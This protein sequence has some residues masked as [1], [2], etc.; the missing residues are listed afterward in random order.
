MIELVYPWKWLGDSVGSAFVLRFPWIDAFMGAVRGAQ[1][2][3]VLVPEA[4]GPLASWGRWLDDR[5][6]DAGMR[7]LLADSGDFRDVTIVLSDAY[8][9]EHRPEGD[10]SAAWSRSFLAECRREMPRVTTVP[11]LVTGADDACASALSEMIRAQRDLGYAFARPVLL[12]RTAPPGWDGEVVRLGLPEWVGDLNRI[13]PPP[14]RDMEFWT[15]L[16][17]ALAVA[18]EAGA[19]P[20]LAEELWDILQ[21]QRTVPLRDTAAFDAWLEQE[22]GDFAKRNGA[23]LD[24]P[25]PTSLAFGPLR[26]ITEEAHWHRGAIAWEEDAFDVTPMQARLWASGLEADA[27]ASL[28]RRRLTNLPLARWLSAWASSIEESLRVAV[29]QAGSSRFR[30][31]LESQQPW[32]R[33]TSFR[34]RL[35]ELRPEGV[36]EVIDSAQFGDLTAFLAKNSPKPIPASVTRLLES[37]RVAR[38]R[39]VHQRLVST[40]DFLDISNTACWLHNNIT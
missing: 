21:L 9:P 3:C 4:A 37:C 35:D 19:V 30:R 28:R 24:T 11:L 27:R 10:P 36:G 38:N 31:F 5:I 25:L 34:S 23:V 16:L 7:A 20:R 22:L 14:S 29:L 40:R 33:G 6:G 18:W 13:A 39:V 32:Q 17:L 12:R 26:I 1:A 8:A 15:N 2:V